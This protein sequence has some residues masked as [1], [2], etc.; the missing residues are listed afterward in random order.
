MGRPKRIQSKADNEA[1]KSGET[2]VPRTRK[3][4]VLTEKN[5][6]SES[7]D[8]DDDF[9]EVSPIV[10]KKPKTTKKTAK[11][12][13]KS[14]G[15][16][17]S[18]NKS[19]G[20]ENVSTNMKSYETKLSTVRT[21]FHRQGSSFA[22]SFNNNFLHMLHGFKSGFVSR[23]LYNRA[24]VSPIIDQVTNFRVAQ[25]VTPFDR[26]V[27]AIAWHPN[28]PYLAAAGS[29][30]G[31]II[32]WDSYRDNSTNTGTLF[33]SMIEG[34]GPGGSIQSLKFDINHSDRVYTASIDGT[35]TRHDFSGKDNKI[36]LETNDWERWYVGMDVSFSGRMMVAGNNKGYVTL[37][38][39]EGEKIWDLKLHKSKCNFVQFSDRQSWMM[40]TTS[41]GAG[42]GS[43]KVW[44]IRNIKGP[45]SA[46]AELHHDKAVNSAY[47]SPLN[48][49]KLL[50]TDQH[51]QLRIYQAPN[52]D[53]LRTIPHPHRQFQ[54]LTPIKACWHP[55]SDIVFAGR[56][57]D[58]NFPDYH[59]GELRT[60]DFFC[61]YSGK[62]F[63]QLV[64]PG[65]SQIISLSQFNSIGDRLLSGM[66]QTVMIWQPKLGDPDDHEQETK[67]AT[68]D[69]NIEGLKVQEWPDFTAKKK[70]VKKKKV[71]QNE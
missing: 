57:P 34:R 48:G 1:C 62:V 67:T 40:V 31:D 26:R 42:T 68:R 59:E 24:S 2:S 41:T 43:V 9:V 55:L 14:D 52:F 17:Q 22:G 54:H 12:K 20:K 65:L 38:S 30:G 58:P 15:S 69:S 10:Q 16:K 29:K 5:V 60:I 32:L 64:Q 47:F 46:L 27:T 3:R 8:P 39:L 35:V 18:R 71:V 4:R 51:S 49:D 19:S 37:L 7:S 36:Y 21:H 53:L 25:L 11:P 6:E 61:P 56:Y 44:D 13:S 63:H 33:K 23:G 50:T 45:G 66:G 70:A 28:Q